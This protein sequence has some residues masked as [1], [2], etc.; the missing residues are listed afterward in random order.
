M[1]AEICCGIDIIINFFLQ[2]YDEQNNSRLLPL[3]VVANNYLRKG[4]L[5]DFVVMLPIG[6]VMSLLDSRLKFFYCFKAIRIFY[7][8]EHASDHKILPIIKSLFKNEQLKALKNP[9]TRADINQDHIYNKECIQVQ[10][11]FKL[12]R[13]VFQIIFLA[14]LAGQYWYVYCMMVYEFKSDDEPTVNFTTKHQSFIDPVNKN[15]LLDEKGFRL[16]LITTYFSMTTLSTIGF[17]DFYP[18][19]DSERIVGSFLLFFGVM[20]FSVFMGLLLEMIEKI[21]SLDFNE[22]KIEELDKFLGYIETK[23]CEDTQLPSKLK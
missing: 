14:Y 6:W 12:V 11:L 2:E 16:V 13:L 1:M 3:S 7:L 22:D 21:N 4:F 5:K 9:K 23:Y 15:S 18:V 20:L 17:G 8:N 10:Y 19:S